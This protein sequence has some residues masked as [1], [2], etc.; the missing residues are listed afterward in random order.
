MGAGR[1]D[2]GLRSAWIRRGQDPDHLEVPLDGAY[3][4]SPP[5]RVGL[6]PGPPARSQTEK[7]PCHGKPDLVRSGSAVARCGK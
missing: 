3:S 1:T 5:A 4:R 6:G 2:P 7:A